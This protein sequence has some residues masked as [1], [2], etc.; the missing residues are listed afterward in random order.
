M[1]QRRMPQLV[2]RRAA[3]S[4][5]EQRLGVPAAQSGMP[6]LR[7]D[8]RRRQLN[9]CPALSNNGPA[10]RPFGDRGSSR[11]LSGRLSRPQTASAQDARGREAELNRQWQENTKHVGWLEGLR[12]CTADSE[13]VQGFVMF[14]WSRWLGQPGG[15]HGHEGT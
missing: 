12:C 1:G 13:A 8:V 9:P 4:F 14:R 2:Q 5:L 15:L 6:G 11:P 7:I 10:V 3:G